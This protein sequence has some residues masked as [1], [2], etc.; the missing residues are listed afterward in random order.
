MSRSAA[1]LGGVLLSATACSDRL[2][3]S[4]AAEL[5]RRDLPADPITIG[6]GDWDH[7]VAQG[8]LRHNRRASFENSYLVTP[9]GEARGL[10]K[11]IERGPGSVTISFVIHVCERV[12]GEVTSITPLQRGAARAAEVSYVRR[13]TTPSSAN[14]LVP[15]ADLW[16]ACDSTARWPARV[17]LVRD[18]A[19]WRINRPPVFDEPPRIQTQYEY[20]AVGRLMGARSTA[21]FAGPPRDPDGDSVTVHWYAP[22]DTVPQV[23]AAGPAGFRVAV[24]HLILMG[25]PQ[26]EHGRLVIMDTW[27]VAD[28]MDVGVAI[29]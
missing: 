16:S 22:G 27:G 19:G 21:T 26:S 11:V 5:L 10:K 28:T 7:L 2:T 4:S 13:A 29:R 25:R 1:W 14:P 3:P 12:P 8:F 24:N 6:A 18:S 17:V 23:I 15:D 9:E 20:D